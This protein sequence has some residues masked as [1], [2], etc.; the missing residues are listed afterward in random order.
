M[1]KVCKNFQNEIWTWAKIGMIKIFIFT[2]ENINFQVF[3]IV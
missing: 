3:E 2:K 1:K